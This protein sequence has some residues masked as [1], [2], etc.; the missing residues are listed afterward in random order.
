[1]ILMREKKLIYIY[2]KPIGGLHGLEMTFC[3][4]FSLLPFQ[5]MKVVSQWKGIPLFLVHFTMLWPSCKTS[6]SKLEY[7]SK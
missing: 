4:E 5:Y 7:E 2:F 3:I 1:M 6:S